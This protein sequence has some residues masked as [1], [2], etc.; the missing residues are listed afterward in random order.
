V[1][2]ATL[3]GDL[4]NPRARAERLEERRVS[5]FASNTTLPASSA[6]DLATYSGQAIG[7]VHVI[8]DVNGYF[9]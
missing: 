5:W 3:E 7:A 9:E 6:G 1:D 8:V 4:Q 2:S